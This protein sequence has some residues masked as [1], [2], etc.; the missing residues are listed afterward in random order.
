MPSEIRRGDPVAPLAPV[1]NEI[2]DYVE[3]RMPRGWTPCLFFWSG[4]AMVAAYPPA[5]DKA[6]LTATLREWC[7]QEDGGA[8]KPA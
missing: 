4:R 2:I 5:V 1:M 7:D 8:G 3:A 6:E